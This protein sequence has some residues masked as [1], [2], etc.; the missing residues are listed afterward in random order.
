MRTAGVLSWAARS[1]FGGRHGV[2]VVVGSIAPGV[3]EFAARRLPAGTGGWCQRDRLADDEYSDL[4]IEGPLTQR[5]L[6]RVRRGGGRLSAWRKLWC[7]RVAEACRRRARRRSDLGNHSRLC[8][9]P[10]RHQQWADGPQSQST[11]KGDP[12]GAGSRGR[13]AC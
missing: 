11:R 5:P 2:F 4:Q 3:P 8:D 7:R 6:T 1:E 12:A 10:Q 13:L 9:W